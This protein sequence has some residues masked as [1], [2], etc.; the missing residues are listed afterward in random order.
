MQQ[1]KSSIVY[2]T[3]KRE[4]Q[5]KYIIKQKRAEKWAIEE[6]KIL[7]ELSHHGIVRMIE[8]NE[9]NGC[10]YLVLEYCKGV[11]LKEYLQN[12]KFD[13]VQI[14]LWG[15]EL[16][17]I[18]KYLHRQKPPIIHR[19]IKPSN[20][21]VLPDKHLKLIDFGIARKKGQKGKAYGTKKFAAP[22]Q[23]KGE[24]SE[25]SDI[26][27]LG[28][29]LKQ[30]WKDGSCWLWKKLLEKMMEKNPEKR[31]TSLQVKNR[32]NWFLFWLK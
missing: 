12:R 3:E 10:V 13:F 32:L 20:I 7:S 27:N 11:T 21:M 16:C 9:K 23:F 28:A 6:G 22:E 5:E 25:K 14:L 2:L 19:D 24:Y 1:N 15:I 30:C 26:N 17:D 18:L 31:Y 29:T 8:Q 4:T